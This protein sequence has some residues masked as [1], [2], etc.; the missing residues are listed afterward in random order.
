[1]RENLSFSLKDLAEKG[2]KTHVGDN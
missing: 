2:M 1:L